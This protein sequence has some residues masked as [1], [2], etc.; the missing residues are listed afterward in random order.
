MVEKGI[1]MNELD[2]R[3]KISRQAV[4]EKFSGKNTSIKWIQ[5]ACLALGVE[6][7][8]AYI[9]HQAGHRI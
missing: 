4:H 7:R 9:N 5:R 3:M 1:R 6:I 2:R 8:V